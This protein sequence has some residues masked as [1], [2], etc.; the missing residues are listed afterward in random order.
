MDFRWRPVN[1]DSKK[2]TKVILHPTAALYEVRRGLETGS[3]DSIDLSPYVSQASHTAFDANVTFSFNREL[4]GSNQP[5]PNQ[6]LEIQLLQD[7][8]YKPCWLGIVDAISSYVQSRGER[9][10]QVIAKSRDSLDIWRN[11]KRVTPLFPQ[12]TDLTYIIQRIAK[13]AGMQHDE[14]VLPASAYTTAHSNTQLADMN[15]WDM[16]NAVALPVGWTPFIDVLGRLRMANRTLVGR[17]PDV[18][19]ADERL[20]K[21]GGQR[22]RPPRSRVRVH[23]LNPTLKKHVEQGQKLNEYTI[24]LGWFL[25]YLYKHVH[26]SVGDTSEKGIQRAENTYYVANPSC[27]LSIGGVQLGYF[28]F[29]SYIQQTE[30]QGK[31][32]FKSL[33]PFAVLGL[34]TSWGLAHRKADQV[35]IDTPTTGHTVSTGR[36]EMALYQIAFCYVMMAIGTGKYEIWGNPFNWVHA[37]NTSEAFDSSVPTWVDN[38]VDIDTDFIVNEEHAKAVSVRELVYQS[39][40]ASKWNVTIVDDPRIEMGD[41]LQFTDGSQLYV[42]NFTRRVERGSEAS[43]D[44][45]GFYVGNVVGI[46]KA[47]VGTVP[48]PPGGQAEPP[49][50]IPPSGAL[51]WAWNEMSGP[52]VDSPSS[53]GPQT[54]DAYRDYFF[55]LIGKTIGEDASDW[56]AVLTGSGIPNGLAPGE[57]PMDGMPHW[58]LTQ[59]IGAGGVRGRLF[60]P[61]SE[62]DA[63]GY[64]SR[65]VDVLAN[66]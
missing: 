64:F 54:A 29:E 65:P 26:F 18:V 2:S 57:V 62:P 30:T 28:V 32:S 10:M 40:E 53:G 22:Q 3:D 45:Q 46:G 42:E 36:L 39:R 8:E 47:I 48:T 50:V 13:S 51:V 15:A 6:V 33:A 37:R 58:A 5:A 31:L 38:A 24:T 55:D 43:L 9:T 4:F 44:I 66:V 23:W 19:L 27:N 7:G 14:I 56:V 35:I 63:L 52:P 25:P 12:L 59:Q 34:I 49:P 61:T 17:Q 16:V 21:V 11:T 41:I 1:R 60:L 20:L